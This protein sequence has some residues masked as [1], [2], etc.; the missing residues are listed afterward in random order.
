MYAGDTEGEEGHLATDVL[1]ASVADTMLFHGAEADVLGHFP[2]TDSGSNMAPH[3]EGHFDGAMASIYIVG[4]DEEGG[5][6]DDGND[7][8]MDDTMDLN[9]FSQDETGADT[10]GGTADGGEDEKLAFAF[11][12]VKELLKFHSGFTI[13][14]KDAVLAAV[15]AVVLLLH[16]LT[17]LA[18]VRAEREGRK[19]VRYSD[20]ANVVH[21]FDQFSFLVD[22]IPQAQ[23]IKE[24]GLMRYMNSQLT[25]LQTDSQANFVGGKHRGRSQADGQPPIRK[26]QVKLSFGSTNDYI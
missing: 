19:T 10:A 7:N 14:S 11:S 24:Q 13:V 8:W 15:D 20:I 6:G 1:G 21:Y 25:N 17:R 2:T 22:I 4:K 16:D 5:D 26:R 12:R 3:E 18:A 23:V 9:V